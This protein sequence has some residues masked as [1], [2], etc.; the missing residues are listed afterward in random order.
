MQ[1]VRKVQS[2]T[3]FKQIQAPDRNAQ[4]T[5]S[6]QTKLY[7]TPCSPGDPNAKEMRWNE[8][9]GDE[10]ME[11]SVTMADFLKSLQATRPTV[12]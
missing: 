11:P 6:G 1:P 5:T 10:L 12:E 3:H 4:P 8:L 2:A 9:K 7:W